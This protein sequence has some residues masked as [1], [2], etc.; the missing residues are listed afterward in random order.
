MNKKWLIH[1]LFFSLSL[2]SFSSSGSTP[3]TELIIVLDELSSQGVRLSRDV[4]ITKD[5]HVFVNRER[6]SPS[7]IIT[8]SSHISQLATFVMKKKNESCSTGSFLH[9]LKNEKVIKK[10]NGCLN[11]ER[12]KM[13]KKH[14][15]AL[16]KDHISH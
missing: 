3:S 13:L 16:K 5:G 1:L 12:Y 4:L 11:S 10:E 15:G 2:L 7:E 6:L 8:Q 14:F 9:I